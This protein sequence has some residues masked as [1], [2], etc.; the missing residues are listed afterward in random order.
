[1]KLTARAVGWI[2]DGGQSNHSP[3]F[4]NK[5][6]V[7]PLER[8]VFIWSDLGRPPEFR[9]TDERGDGFASGQPYYASLEEALASLEVR[10]YGTWSKAYVTKFKYTEDKKAP[11]GKVLDV[12]FDSHQENAGHYAT[13]EHAEIEANLIKLH[14]VT[15]DSCNGGRHVIRKFGV[16]QRKP[17]EFV[18]SCEGPFTRQ[19]IAS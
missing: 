9:I 4:A 15:I 12:W 5:W 2:S 11:H 3:E 7:E 17:G 1:M 6:K 19:A 13:R 10:L 14:E 8:D 16:E 18:I